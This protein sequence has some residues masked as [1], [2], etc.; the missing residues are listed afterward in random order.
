MSDVAARPR[1][2]VFFPY[3]TEVGGSEMRALEIT[4][5]LRELCGADAQ[6]WATSSRSRAAFRRRHGIRRFLPWHLR[7]GGSFVFVGT[8]WKP[9]RLLRLTRPQQLTVIVN[10][11]EPGRFA[12]FLPLYRRICP[13]V[14]FVYTCEL[15]RRTH[16][17]DG[18]IHLSPID[19][20]RFAPEPARPA[21][22]AGRL[23]VGRCSRDALDKHH[24]L[25]DPELY[26]QLSREGMEFDLLGARS[27]AP[28]LDPH[29]AI[30]LRPEGELEVASFLRG[31]DVFFYRTGTFYDPAARVVWEAMACGLPVVCHRFAGHADHIVHGETGFVF[32]EQREAIEILRRL[33]DDPALR[34]RIGRNARRAIEARFAPERLRNMLATYYAAPAA[35]EPGAASPPAARVVWP[36]QEKEK[37]RSVRP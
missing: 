28:L 26:A 6:L 22:V 37:T 19:L 30:R 3:A 21:A 4:R 11:M 18:D 1:V 12:N 27:L 35:P 25:Y 14:R 29:P 20:Q 13:A 9:S 24:A 36:Q 17:V 5:Q 23:R 32:D 33:R 10:T 31:L 2:H 15:Q 16:G 8:F 7:L 34:E